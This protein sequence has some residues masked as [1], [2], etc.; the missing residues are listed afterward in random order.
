MS[1]GASLA[2]LS[3]A[4][5]ELCLTMGV[6]GCGL[7]CNDEGAAGLTLTIVDATNGD[8]IC[9]AAVRYETPDLVTYGTGGPECIYTAART[10]GTY[11]ITVQHMGYV[12]QTT[13]VTVAEDECGAAVPRS[14]RIALTRE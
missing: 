6:G 8:A 7:S 1:F 4:A 5:A 9:D 10:P 14:L 13:T 3:L 2:R 12:T 11:V